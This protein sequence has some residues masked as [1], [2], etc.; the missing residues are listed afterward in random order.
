MHVKTIRYEDMVNYKKTSM[1]I[2]TVSCG[3][4]C[5]VEAGLPLSVCQNDGWRSCA[6]IEIS[7]RTI[8]KKYLSNPIT[9]PI[10]IGGLEPF[11]QFEEILSLI[12]MLRHDY[13]CGDDIVI[14]TG[15]NPD[16]IAEQVAQLK[17]YANIIIK[18]GRFVPNKPHHYDDVLGV[19][20]SSDNQFAERIS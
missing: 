13:Q 3:G 18:F 20:L 2:G 15:Y 17:K 19:I 16:E 11:E 5:C 6:S 10:V 14:Y 12:C 4:K 1:F 7:N 8:C 9:K